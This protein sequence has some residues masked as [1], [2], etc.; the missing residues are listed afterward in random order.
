MRNG[1]QIIATTFPFS[2]LISRLDCAQLRTRSA[3]E[4]GRQSLGVSTMGAQLARQGS[5]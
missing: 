1:A 5:G 2:R 4:W 3:V